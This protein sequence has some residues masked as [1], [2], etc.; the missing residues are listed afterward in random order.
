[1]I[2]NNN[3]CK[4]FVDSINLGFLVLISSFFQNA[5]VLRYV[6][7]CLSIVILVAGV[8]YLIRAVSRKETT[9]KEILTAGDADF[10]CLGIWLLVASLAFSF[11]FRTG[12]FVASGI[13]ILL[14]LATAAS[15]LLKKKQD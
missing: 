7:L 10:V 13:F 2:M 11:G 5:Q 14:L 3:V 1:M 8:V 15:L 9:F 6:L 12:G 4:R